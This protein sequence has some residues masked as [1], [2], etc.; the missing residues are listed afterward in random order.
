M[1]NYDIIIV[2]GG[3]AGLTAGIY[4]GR[5]GKRAAIIGGLFPGGRAALTE[6]IEN[7]SG[8][9][10]IDGF[11]LTY[12][13]KEQ[14]EKFGAEFIDGEAA[15]FD[16]SNKEKKII[17]EDGRELSS[18]AIIIATGTTS[19]KLGV[20]NEDKLVGRGISYCATCDGGFFKNK[21]VAVVGGGDTAVTDAL[22]LK[23]LAKEV[24]LIHRRP[25]FR[26]TESLASRLAAA[27][28]KCLM[29]S[30]VIALK[31]EPLEA[32]S[33]LNVKTGEITEIKAN[34]L[35]VAIGSIPN[36]KQLEGKLDLDS[37]GYIKTDGRMRTSVEGVYAA[38]D[39]RTTPLRQVIT[40]CADGAVA[41][42][43]AINEMI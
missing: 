3:P 43:E 25:V 21:V 4:A 26:A 2:G 31:G 20:E 30:E 9:L 6:K 16:F 19:R 33:V 37:Y 11:G 41:V 39:V 27:G 24:W 5:A 32:I 15:F 14:A 40:A 22:Y 34:G 17:L 42:T 8:V 23:N 36:T 12:K 7:F 35:F 1:D 10:E 29:E 38:G 28:V 18:P 13:M